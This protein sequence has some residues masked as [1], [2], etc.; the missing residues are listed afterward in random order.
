[1]NLD[2]Y[3]GDDDDDGD[4][5][6]VHIDEL[7]YVHVLNNRLLLSLILVGFGALGW[8]CDRQVFQL[9]STVGAMAM[10]GTAVLFEKVVHDLDIGR[11]EGTYYLS[12][13]WAL[14]GVAAL[15]S[16]VKAGF[17]RSFHAKMIWLNDRLANYW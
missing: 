2:K 11:L 9:F 1:M 3:F 13:G 6:Y 10:I 5:D 4:G 15:L 7:P 12:M 14:L 17:V 16:I 8:C